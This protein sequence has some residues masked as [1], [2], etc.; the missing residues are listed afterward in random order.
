MKIAGKVWGHTKEIIKGSAFEVHR[1]EIN[2]GGFCS[3]HKH[4][5]KNNAFFVE[6]GIVEVEVHK[7]DYDLVDKTKLIVGEMVIV[8]AGENHRFKGIEDSIVYE[9]YWLDD[10]NDDIV[11]IEVGGD[12]KN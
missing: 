11:R 1:I 8:K 6:S 4:N 5:H 9:I 10:I 12:E 2:K 7:N 3:L